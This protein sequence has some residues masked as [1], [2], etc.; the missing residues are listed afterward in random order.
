MTQKI[1]VGIAGAG[2]IGAVHAHAYQHIP[3]VEIVG[4]ADPIAEKVEPLARETN[5]RAFRDYSELLDAGV[6]ILNV[7][8]PPQPHLAAAVA[9]AKAGTH[10]LMEKPIART[11]AE[12]DE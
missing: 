5:S 12:A 3:D 1:R 11:L 8:L 7:C 10:V 2:F 4:I 6:D 9:A